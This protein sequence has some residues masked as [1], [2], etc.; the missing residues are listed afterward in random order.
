MEVLDLTVILEGCLLSCLH[1]PLPG[2]SALS[3]LAQGS[4]C[5]VRIAVEVE[6]WIGCCHVGDLAG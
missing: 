2:T 1:P 3:H 6:S 4:L 5:W